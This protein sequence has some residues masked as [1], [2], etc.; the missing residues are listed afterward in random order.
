VTRFAVLDAGTPGLDLREAGFGFR[1]YSGAELAATREP[2]V[3]V[4][5]LQRGGLVRQRA[6]VGA[7]ARGVVAH[8]RGQGW[9]PHPALVVNV[10]IL[11]AT[12]VICRFAWTRRGAWRGGRLDDDDRIVPCS[13]WCSWPTPS[14]ATPTPRTRS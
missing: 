1:R 6:P 12:A 9:T 7:E 14:S 11:L 10:V 5:R 8:G 2:A 13:R 3:R 4:L